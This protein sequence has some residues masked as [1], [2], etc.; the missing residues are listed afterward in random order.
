[1]V[2]KEISIMKIKRF[3]TFLL[4]CVMVLTCTATA[5]ASDADSPN[6]ST[7]EAEA[8]TISVTLA[9]A[10]SIDDNGI[11]PLIWGQETPAIID[12]ASYTSPDFYVSDRYFAFEASAI[13]INGQAVNGKFSVALISGS[14]TKASV[15]GDANGTISKKDWI[16]MTPGDYHFKISNNTSSYLNFTVT[17]YS[18]P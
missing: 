12:N 6:A 11:M 2:T 15:S 14:S 1:M 9:P 3:F 10:E 7:P 16:T 18:W 13:G 8:H 5:F 17:Y 4:T